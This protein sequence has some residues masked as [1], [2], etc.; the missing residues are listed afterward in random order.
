MDA[1]GVKNNLCPLQNLCNYLIKIVRGLSLIEQHGLQ[2]TRNE[3]VRRGKKLLWQNPDPNWGR[4]S[5]AEFG[6][7]VGWSTE[8]PSIDV[9]YMGYAIKP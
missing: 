1:I 7:R 2:A 9:Y 4:I 5:A 6:K 3:I 8:G